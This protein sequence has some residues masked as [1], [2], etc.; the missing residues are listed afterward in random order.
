MG[1]SSCRGRASS[2]PMLQSAVPSP[3][4][5]HLKFDRQPTPQ[6][7]DGRG[8]VS[9]PVPDPSGSHAKLA[10]GDRKGLEDRSGDRAQGKR[11]RS[12]DRGSLTAYERDLH[13]RRDS[14]PTCFPENDALSKQLNDA[15]TESALCT[16]ILEHHT[17]FIGIHTV[18][19]MRKLV[20]LHNDTFRVPAADDLFFQA[21]CVLEQCV[22]QQVT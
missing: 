8:G 17:V 21:F 9:R 15:G 7:H 12:E 11:S 10:L 20:L 19:A 5:P 13:S 14:T 1:L 18:S 4:W 3:S 22:Y 2:P 16:M 6:H